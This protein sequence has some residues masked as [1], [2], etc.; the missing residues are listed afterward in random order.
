MGEIGFYVCCFYFMYLFIFF[1]FIFFTVNCDFYLFY[2]RQILL[3]QTRYILTK[4]RRRYILTK[5]R[6]ISLSQNISFFCT[7]GAPI[8]QLV[9]HWPTDLVVSGL[10]PV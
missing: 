8:V 2:F 6:R 5:F 9:K 3:L 4:F 7:G 1:F 10:S